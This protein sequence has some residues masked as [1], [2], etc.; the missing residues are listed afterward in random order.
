MIH[1]PKVVTYLM[2]LVMGSISIGCYSIDTVRPSELQTIAGEDLFTETMIGG[3]SVKYHK[4]DIDS[5]QLS[6]TTAKHYIQGRIVSSAPL[7]SIQSIQ[8]KS[9]NLPGTMGLSAVTTMVV[10]YFIVVSSVKGMRI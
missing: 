7:D 9:F 3:R 2:C 5:L 8:T 4:G 1:P 10:L 6:G